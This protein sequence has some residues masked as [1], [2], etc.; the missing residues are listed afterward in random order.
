M[1]AGQPATEQCVVVDGVNFLNTADLDGTSLPP[2]G[3]PN[4]VLAAGGT[5]LHYD[6]D[7]DGLYVW[8]M[9]VDWTRPANTALTGPRKIDVTPYR[10]LCGGQPGR[11]LHD[12]VR[13]RLP[14]VR[15]RQLL[16]PR[17]G[18]APA[19]L[20][21]VTAATCTSA[22]SAAAACR[23]VDARRHRPAPTRSRGWSAR[24]RASAPGRGVALRRPAG[25]SGRGCRS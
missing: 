8:K 24:C 15:R 2:A 1:L 10:Y 20:P 4:L 21:A 25:D 9:H 13:G 12:L 17:G 7:D 14:E 22:R 16:D 5:Q 11:R 6:L 23:C 18:R 3:A 19:H